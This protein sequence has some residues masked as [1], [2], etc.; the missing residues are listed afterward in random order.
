MHVGLSVRH[1][2]YRMHWLGEEGE[3]RGGRALCVYI[4]SSF[5]YWI[6][7]LL[8]DVIYHAYRYLQH[9]YVKKS[10]ISRAR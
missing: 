6:V 9:F 5:P 7:I 3:R 2:L 1:S 4:A 8:Y 10:R